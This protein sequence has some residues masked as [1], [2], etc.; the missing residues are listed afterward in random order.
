MST[1][2]LPHTVDFRTLAARQARVVG[3]VALEKLP[4]VQAAVCHAEGPARVSG[5]FERD[6]MGRYTCD[7]SVEMPVAVECQ[8]C[9]QPFSVHLTARSTLAALW[10][11]AQASDLPPDVD[12]LVTAEDT[13]LWAVVEDELLLVLPPYPLHDDPACAEAVGRVVPESAKADDDV[14]APKE[15]PFA[16]LA[17]LQRDGDQQND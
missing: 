8:R 2:G 11:D 3:S 9:L 13:D 14:E 4:R 17:A 5:V 12:P 16:M 10:T 15:N 6:P 1:G 7:I